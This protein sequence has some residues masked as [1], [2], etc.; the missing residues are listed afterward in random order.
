MKLQ[1]KFLKTGLSSSEHET[2]IDVHPDEDDDAEVG[3]Q[4]VA[5]E[6]RREDDPPSRT[7]AATFM[8]VKNIFDLIKDF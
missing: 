8:A 6:E 4:R 3:V 5:D 7:A 2:Y 1:L